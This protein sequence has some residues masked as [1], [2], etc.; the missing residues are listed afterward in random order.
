MNK[1][2]GVLG[3][4]LGTSSV[5]MLLN[6][7][8]HTTIKVRE[9]YEEPTP[10]GW[11]RAVKK[12]MSGLN[13]D[14][15][16]AIGLT[17]QVGTYIV[18][19]KEILPW[20]GKEGAKELAELKEKCGRELFLEEVSMPHPNLISYPLPRL[21]YIQKHWPEAARVCQPKDFLCEM[22]TGTCV[23]DPYSW[24]GLA[25]LS[26]HRYSGKLLDR[27]GFPVRKLPEMRRP[28]EL[29]GY[30]KETKLNGNVLPGGIPVFV[31]MN[32][33]FASLLGMGVLE[34]GD[35]FDISGTSEHLGVVEASVNPDT[36][37]VSGP[38]LSENVHYGVTA[39]AGVSLGYGMELFG[40]NEVDP[41]QNLRK[42]PPVF[43]PYLNGERAPIWDAGAQGM[44]F[45]IHGECRK[46]DMAYAVLEG[47][48]FS[49]YHIYESMG[50]P[51][52]GSM[53]VSG[54]AA[55]NPVLNQMKAELF[56]VPVV[57]P[58]ETD[59]SALG[60]CMTAAIGLGW[61]TDFAE[62]VRQNVRIRER[63]EPCG[64]YRQLLK[65]RF[66]I[67]KELYPATKKQ[68]ERINSLSKGGLDL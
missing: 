36:D 62:A 10:S 2:S 51:P 24:R 61:S 56:D 58:E 45:G 55:A 12:A 43:L 38:Y 9:G 16:S 20:S 64:R 4:D 59:T 31:G 41:I 15:I 34:I 21:M 54:G 65:Q 40:F 14:G 32:D 28:T 30:T 50:S 60:A 7:E 11:W 44:F 46:S 27:I 39:S 29:A 53:C 48:V 5:K 13:L 19:E 8:D 37:L 26:E 68:C 23:T 47:V 52:A 66:E 35:L 17:S 63:V 67:Y 25:N 42:K 18:D 33:F 3:I 6:D 49:L 1:R 22:L 57:V